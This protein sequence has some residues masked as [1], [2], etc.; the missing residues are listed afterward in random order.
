MIA[1]VLAFVFVTLLVFA[2]P[3]SQIIIGSLYIHS[4]PMND[5]IPIYLIVAGILTFIFLIISI[6]KVKANYFDIDERKSIIF[7]DFCCEYN[8]LEIHST[9]SWFYLSWLVY[10]CQFFWKKNNW[11]YS[12]VFYREMF[13]HFVIEILFNIMILMNIQPI[14]NIPYILVHIQ[15][16]SLVMLICLV[17]HVWL[18]NDRAK[19]RGEHIPIVWE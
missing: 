7:I 2:L 4:C 10:H 12:L 5:L 6:V 3:I 11:K 1:I 9:C 13:G 14:V 19:M 8:R 18:I 16:Y 15:Q 17:V